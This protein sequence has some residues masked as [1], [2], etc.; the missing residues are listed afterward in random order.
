MNTTGLEVRNLSAAYGQRLALDAVSFTLAPGQRLAVIGTSGSGKS[1]LLRL[2]AGLDAPVQGEI[3]LDGV[4]VS[5]PG[6]VLVEPHD[7]ALGMVFQ[8]L[9]LWPALS[10]LDNVALGLAGALTGRTA[11]RDRALEA[12]A[13]CGVAELAARNPREMSGGQQQRVALARALAVTPRWLLLDEPFGGL[14]I[15]TKEQL[16]RDI[17][18]I[19]E[20]TGRGVVLV[21]HDP[22]EA[23][24]L[25]HQVLV[26][27]A[28]RTVEA[29]EL[30]RLLES[31]RS[32]IL[33]A[34]Q[35]ILV[36]ASA[37]GER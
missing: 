10:A 21:T 28:G 35:R 33:Q 13:L 36:R 37:A 11:A 3:Y 1:T 5:K 12:L 34:F 8:D 16:T 27:E 18:A 2:I 32:S 25:C 17:L 26:L 29:G 9:A 14:D 15:V 22:L 4:Q 24:Q 20:H 6:A 19:L 31:P 30:A 23:A 7:R